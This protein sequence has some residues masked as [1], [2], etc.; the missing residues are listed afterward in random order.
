MESEH[1][2][3]QPGFERK[4][5]KGSV[6]LSPPCLALPNPLPASATHPPVVLM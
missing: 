2:V 3:S 5:S 1:D 4:P 6:M